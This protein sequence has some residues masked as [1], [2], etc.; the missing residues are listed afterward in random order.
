MVVIFKKNTNNKN[1]G[2]KKNTKLFKNQMWDHFRLI[3]QLERKHQLTYP[4]QLAQNPKAK[5][6]TNHEDGKSAVENKLVTVIFPVNS[7][8]MVNTL[9]R[10]NVT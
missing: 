1:D 3:L 7:Y 4:S 8:W 10:F 5:L 6:S 9:S 2:V